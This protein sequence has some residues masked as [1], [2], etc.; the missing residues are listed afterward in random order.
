V[1]DRAGN[2]FEG[3]EVGFYLDN[4][5]SEI[6][7]ISPVDGSMVEGIIDV[8]VKVLE[9]FSEEISFQL[10]NGRW[11]TLTEETNGTFTG[12]VDTTTFADEN[13]RLTVKA[14]DTAGHS[15][16]EGIDITIDNSAPSMIVISPREGQTLTGVLKIETWAEDDIGV[17]EVTATAGDWSQGLVMDPM[18]GLYW[19]YLDTVKFSDGP[20]DLKVVA[21]D[22]IGHETASTI[23]IA[24]LNFPDI[25]PPEGVFMDPIDGQLVAGI[26]DVTVSAK[27]EAGIKSV[28]LSMAGGALSELARDQ[29]TGHYTTKVDTTTLT[30]G[31]TVLDATLTNLGGKTTV[32]TVTVIVDNSG[33]VIILKKP[34]TVEGEARIRATVEDPGGVESVQYKVDGGAWQ[35]M[36]KVGEGYEAYWYTDV[37]DN[38]IHVI[39][40]RAVDSL[41]NEA[42]ES[43]KVEVNNFDWFAAGMIAFVVVILVLVALTLMFTLKRRGKGRTPVSEVVDEDTPP[44]KAK[45]KINYPEMNEEPEPEL[46]AEQ[47][48]TKSKGFVIPPMPPSLTGKEA[49]S[50]TG[51]GETS[52]EEE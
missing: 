45:K 9:D 34:G 38:G 5:A 42:R 50:E 46:V 52:N 29:S 32:I 27:D 4:D 25:P 23:T 10:G 30:D 48:E 24:T 20:L 21:K 37:P 51:S 47:E 11:T 22:G 7:I 31:S 19:A 3:V 13:Y 1:T 44:R 36:A 41:G 2:E 6:D 14:E 35:E 40:V 39:E 17:T 15:V 12:Q 16:T 18:T 43:A 33:P 26:I 28:E 8:R 49:E